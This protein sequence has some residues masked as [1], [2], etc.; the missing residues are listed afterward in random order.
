MPFSNLR[1][2]FSWILSISQKKKLINSYR[3]CS[4]GLQLL[5]KRLWHRC[6]PVNFSKFLR[7]T[8]LQN[9]SGRLLLLNYKLKC[10]WYFFREICSLGLLEKKNQTAY[11]KGNRKTKLFSFYNMN[12]SNCSLFSLNWFLKTSAGGSV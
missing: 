5:K 11:L 2:H 12:K 6:S 4:F 3:C 1:E 8:F 10:G 7:T 9:T